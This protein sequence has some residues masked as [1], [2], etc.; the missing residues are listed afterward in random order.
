MQ[1]GLEGT[2]K[3]ASLAER[4]GWFTM[5]PASTVLPTMATIMS[6]APMTRIGLSLRLAAPAVTS[7]APELAGTLPSPSVVRLYAS[8]VVGTDSTVHHNSLNS[9]VDRL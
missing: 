4:D 2:P 3:S 7:V 8:S 6:Y 1:V 5:G 9:W